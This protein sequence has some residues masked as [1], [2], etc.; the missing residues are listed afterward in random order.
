MLHVAD[1]IEWG[2]LLLEESGRL[3]DRTHGPRVGVLIAGQ[4]AEAGEIGDVLLEQVA[5]TRSSG[6]E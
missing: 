3:E 2:E 6:A 4:L 1:T 5:R